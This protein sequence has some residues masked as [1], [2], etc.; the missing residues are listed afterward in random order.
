[1]EVILLK[2]IQNLGKQGQII[3][4]KDGYGRN[5]LIPRKLAAVSTPETHKMVETL[6][7]K[8]DELRKKSKAGA[9]ELAKKIASLSCTIAVEAGVEDKIFGSVTPEMIRNT[10]RQESIEIDKKDILIDEQ[11]KKLGVYQVNI[12]LD[13]EVTAS[14]KVWIVKK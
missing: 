11:I 9:E 12:K 8:E 1:M 13:P 4:V 3:D 10:L 7:K 5:Y 2:D 6:K 14:L